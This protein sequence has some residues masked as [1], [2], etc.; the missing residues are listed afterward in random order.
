MI[1]VD[2]AGLRTLTGHLF[3]LARE[4]T[5]DGTRLYLDERSGLEGGFT[6]LALERCDQE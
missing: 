4:G 1:E 2:A 3:T 5:P 6:R